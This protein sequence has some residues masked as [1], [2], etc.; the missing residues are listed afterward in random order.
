MITNFN[1]K[2]SDLWPQEKYVPAKL[3]TLGIET[4]NEVLFNTQTYYQQ[5]MSNYS[6][7]NLKSFLKDNKLYLRK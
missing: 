7:E 1:K 2:L 6:V 5:H 4:I 3:K